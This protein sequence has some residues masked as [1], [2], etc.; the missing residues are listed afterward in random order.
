MMYKSSYKE[1]I[2]DKKISTVYSGFK[3]RI[4]KGD[5]SED[6]DLLVLRSLKGKY[7]QQLK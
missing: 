1:L 3:K 5:D 7:Q 2:P 6:D 4:S